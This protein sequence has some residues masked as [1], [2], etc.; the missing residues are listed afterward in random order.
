MSTVRAPAPA[1]C[2]P[3]PPSAADNATA[4]STPE[5]SR[6]GSAEGSEATPPLAPPTLTQRRPGPVDWPAHLARLDELRTKTGALPRGA[7]AALAAELGVKV[8]TVYSQVSRHRRD[9]A[10]REQGRA[11]ARAQGLAE[12]TKPATRA[13]VSADPS[14]SDPERQVAAPAQTPPQARP[15]VAD[16]PPGTRA[17]VLQ[18]LD[19]AEPEA[20]LIHSGSPLPG[21]HR[22]D[23]KPAHR[24]ELRCPGCAALLTLALADPAPVA[25]PADPELIHSGSPSPAAEHKHRLD[26]TEPGLAPTH[27]AA[28]PSPPEPCQRTTSP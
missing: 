7:L 15:L 2:A 19:S 6:P 10:L 14:C 20:E 22:T 12:H 17:A 21:T 26:P 13:A 4:P 28:N 25:G 23:H 16:Q 24:A 1:S 9:E 5:A 3:H 27:A 18:R 8:G 11:T